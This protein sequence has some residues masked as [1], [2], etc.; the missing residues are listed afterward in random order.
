MGKEGYLRCVL[1]IG[2]QSEPGSSSLGA[3]VIACLP[4][5]WPSPR[6]ASS[7]AAAGTGCTGSAA[8]GAG[9]PREGTRLKQAREINVGATF[10][11]IKTLEKGKPAF[12]KRGP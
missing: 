10:G 9:S 7:A 5:G 2:R 6:P 1:F 11:P 3:A 8:S 12:T 4:G